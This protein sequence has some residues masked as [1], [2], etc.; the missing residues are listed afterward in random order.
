MAESE[1]VGK[2]VG[3]SEA[4]RPTG[5]RARG[6]LGIVVRGVDSLERWSARV[7]PGITSQRLRDRER[8]GSVSPPSSRLLRPPQGHLHR[9]LLLPDPTSRVRVRDRRE[10]EK[11]G[12][13]CPAPAVLRVHEW[14]RVLC[15]LLWRQRES[16]TVRQQSRLSARRSG[17]QRRGRRWVEEEEEVTRRRCRRL[18]SVRLDGSVSGEVSVV[19]R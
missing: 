1:G 18:R 16:T 5:A 4:A 12:R 11:Q 2:V 13:G 6:Q 15:L 7:C 3:A 17:K 10:E 9:R 14:D 8:L 19:G